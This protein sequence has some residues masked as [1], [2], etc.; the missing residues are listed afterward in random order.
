M[1][2]SIEGKDGS[3]VKKILALLICLGLACSVGCSDT[4]STKTSA[5]GATSS[6]K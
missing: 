3:T 6:A 4:K 2:S 5:G 1:I